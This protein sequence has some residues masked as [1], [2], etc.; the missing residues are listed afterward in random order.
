MTWLLDTSIIVQALRQEPSVLRRLAPLSPDDIV[1][2]AVAIAELAYGGL[3]SRDPTRAE[4]LWRAFTEP[5]AVLPFDA[6]AAEAHARL[7]LALRAQPIGERDLFL[8]ASAVASGSI[9]VTRNVGEFERVP[10]LT[11]EAWP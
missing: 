1:V 7:R 11:V 8:A 4:R 2:P 3:R 6:V 10:G 9:V 5:Y